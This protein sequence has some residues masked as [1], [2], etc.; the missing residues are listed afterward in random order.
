MVSQKMLSTK[1]LNKSQELAVQNNKQ[2]GTSNDIFTYVHVIIRPNGTDYAEN[3]EE[4]NDGTLWL[5][6]DNQCCCFLFDFYFLFSP[7]WGLEHFKWCLNGHAELNVIDASL[8]LGA[9]ICNCQIHV[10]LELAKYV[11]LHANGEPLLKRSS[12]HSH[13]FQFHNHS[14]CCLVCQRR[15]YIV[16]FQGEFRGQIARW[17]CVTVIVSSFK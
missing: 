8:S 7:Q 17:L 3:K 13:D 15:Q 4:N 2:P 14:T 11:T 12:S 1:Q 10:K 5:L 16:L 9:C 6:Q